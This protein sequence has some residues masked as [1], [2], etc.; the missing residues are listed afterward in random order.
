MKYAVIENNNVVNTIICESKELAEQITGLTCIE[1]TDE[2]PAYIGGTYDGTNFIPP[3]PY[4]SWN[5]NSEKLW[6][7]PISVPKDGK[8]Y[9]WVEEDLN[10]QV[11]PTE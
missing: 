2:N 3:S 10:W 8:L 7:P 5:L 9:R 4:L 11:I 1:Y 6:E